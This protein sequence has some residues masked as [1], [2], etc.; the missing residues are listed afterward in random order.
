M[1]KF[2]PVLI[3]AALVAFAVMSTAATNVTS[4]IVTKQAGGSTGDSTVAAADT[5]TVV[6]IPRDASAWK[7]VAFSDSATIY[8]VQVQ[9]RAGGRWY[10]IDIDT[11][12]A[13]AA[14]ESSADFGTTYNGWACRII[15]DVTVT[16]KTTDLGNVALSVTR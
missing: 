7:V 12:A 3:L 16:P 13:G 6:A 5:S 2:R 8:V 10:T 4:T 1:R 15:Q 11:T 9:V 14:V